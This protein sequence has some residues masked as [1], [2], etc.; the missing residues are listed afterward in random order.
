MARPSASDLIGFKFDPSPGAGRIDQQQRAYVKSNSGKSPKAPYQ[1]SEGS[2]DSS[3]S[4][5]TFFG[6]QFEDQLAKSNEFFSGD[7]LGNIM[8]TLSPGFQ[9]QADRIAKRSTDR[10][11]DAFRSTGG[12]KSSF[13]GARFAENARDN[14]LNEIMGLTQAATGSLGS[15]AGGYN[16]MLSTA[17]RP[18][19]QSE[20]SSSG[21]QASYGFGPQAPPI[22]FAPGYGSRPSLSNPNAGLKQTNAGGGGGSAALGLPPLVQPTPDVQPINYGSGGG[23]SNIYHNPNQGYTNVPNQPSQHLYGA[24]DSGAEDAF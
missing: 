1:T 17:G 24:G 15:I 7:V 4:S 2:Q 10:L 8:Q 21:S 11:K 23:S 13:A 14:A 3:S 6:D 16:N 22:Q 12:M 18:L 19:S 20:S 5:S 9:I